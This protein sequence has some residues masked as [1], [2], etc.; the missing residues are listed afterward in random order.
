MKDTTIS[1]GLQWQGKSPIRTT[2]DWPNPLGV[3]IEAMINCLPRLSFD[4]LQMLS[5][6]CEVL[7]GE[8]MRQRLVLNSGT[9]QVIVGGTRHANIVYGGRE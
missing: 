6:I 9:T 8:I 7:M 2:V 1:W 3:R 5:R 4:L